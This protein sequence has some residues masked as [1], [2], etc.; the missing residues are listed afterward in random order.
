M[1][2]RII[3]AGAL[4]LVAAT[5]ATAQA[6][7]NGLQ[8]MMLFRSIVQ[9]DPACAVAVTD[10]VAAIAGDLGTSAASSCPDA[11]AWAQFGTAIT[12]EFWDWAIDTTVWRSEPLPLCSATVTSDCC[13]P[14]AVPDPTS[15][16]TQCPI[17][18]ADYTPV[19]PLPALPNGT[20][21]GA[22]VNHR[23]LLPADL[24]DPGR[25]LRDLELELVFR[26]RP[27]FEYLYRNDLYSKEGMGARNRAQNAAI[28]AGNI[29]AAQR[30]Q[31]RLPVDAVMVK[32]DF[33]HQ[34][35]MLEEGLI[36]IADAGGVLLDPPNNPDY[37][38]LTVNLPGDGS[39][40]TVPGMYY[41]V[42]MT[43]ASK[44]IPIWHWYAM[45][46][47]AN[48][49][50]CDYIGC[51]D[52]FG[53]TVNGAAQPGADFGS[54]FIAPHITLNDDKTSD[55]D[56]LFQNGLAYDPVD[57]GEVITPVLAAMLDALGVGTSAIDSDPNTIT[58]DDPAWRNYRLKGTQTTFT[59]A[60]GIPS[61]MGAT[62]T[63]GGFVNSAS[64]TTCHS[65]ASFD[66]YGNSGMQGVGATWRPNL[67]GYGQVA[68]G[69]PD[70][71]WFYNFG[72]SSVNATQID[73][74][75][76]VLFASC[77]KDGENGECASYPDAPTII[78]HY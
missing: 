62:V 17:F 7:V 70:A 64:C 36:Q 46:H 69:A 33:V 51:N 78:D 25:L 32:A 41:M 58:V 3:A 28:S 14:N 50:R 31:V 13:D 26:N 73:F 21:S 56:P 44:D 75:W 9:D 15:P 60:T 6:N 34:D 43:N 23:G 48:L 27:M 16:S 53:Y 4:V 74:I 66:E 38:Y 35:I 1:R 2:M 72:N 11:F 37:P 24:S 67:Q 52:S 5:G 61:G 22:V 76:G 40:G 59:Q 65:Q 54:S 63:E 47:V 10:G 29:G 68:M 71:N 8:K 39:A 55:N 30:L 20:P 77:Q 45:E 57:T 18:R 49:G 12:E 19:P 42:A